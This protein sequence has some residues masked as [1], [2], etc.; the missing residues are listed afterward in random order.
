MDVNDY[1]SVDSRETLKKHREQGTL[2]RE[3]LTGNR[4]E[5]GWCFLRLLL[6]VSKRASDGFP[7]SQAT[8]VPGRFLAK[9]ERLI[10][11]TYRQ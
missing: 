7:D 5:G 4:V 6:V 1:F 9:R 10:F 3:R 2:N 11:L 8:R